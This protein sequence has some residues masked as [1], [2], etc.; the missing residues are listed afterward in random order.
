MNETPSAHTIEARSQWPRRQR[1]AGRDFAGRAVGPGRPK[2]DNGAVGYSLSTIWYERQRF[3]PAIL[4][5]SFSA[6]LVAV[7]CG[8]VLGLLSMMSRPVDKARADVW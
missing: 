4:A 7:Q 2:C 5:V 1:R 8:L 6:V 3:L